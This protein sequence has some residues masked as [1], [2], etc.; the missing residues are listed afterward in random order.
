MFAVS[1]VAVGVDDLA[2]FWASIPLASIGRGSSPCIVRTSIHPYLV[3]S[4]GPK[5]QTGMVPNTQLP[6]GP[7]EAGM[8]PSSQSPCLKWN[9]WDKPN[10]FFKLM[11]FKQGFLGKGWITALTLLCK[12]HTICLMSNGKSWL[13]VSH[14]QLPG[15]TK[16]GKGHGAHFLNHLFCITLEAAKLHMLIGYTGVNISVC[17]GSR[18]LRKQCQNIYW[19]NKDLTHRETLKGLRSGRSCIRRLVGEIQGIP[20]QRRGTNWAEKETGGKSWMVMWQ[21]WRLKETWRTRES[22]IALQRV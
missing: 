18:W 17:K 2:L 15:F 13:S 14:L 6:P 8:P 16:T 5:L 7:F 1:L 22:G 4:G 10:I 19:R 20:D 21:S 12:N 9:V 3:S 11:E